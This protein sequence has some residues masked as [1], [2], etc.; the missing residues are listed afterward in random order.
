LQPRGTSQLSLLAAAAAAAAH[1]A[2][3]H[4]DEGKGAATGRDSDVDSRAQAS[5]PDAI[6]AA[7]F[8]GP[9][10]YIPANVRFVL[11]RW[12]TAAVARVDLGREW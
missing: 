10:R 3:D 7:N 6:T 5:M 2:Q 1:D 11:A 12:R 8:L 4:E 9:G